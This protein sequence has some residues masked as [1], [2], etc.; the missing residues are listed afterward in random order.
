MKLYNELCSVLLAHGKKASIQ[1]NEKK[2]DNYH[3]FFLIFFLNC[4]LC[5][6]FVVSFILI[7]FYLDM[8]I[9]EF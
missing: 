6:L 3:V 1:R 5:D 8:L 9:E 4:V 7:L 2:L